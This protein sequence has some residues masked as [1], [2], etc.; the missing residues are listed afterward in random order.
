MVDVSLPVIW[1]LLI[2]EIQAISSL[3]TREY[4]EI[5]SSWFYHSNKR[6]YNCHDRVAKMQNMPNA[7]TR[8]ESFKNRNGC[9]NRISDKP[10]QSYNHLQFH[11]CYCNHLDNSFNSYIMLQDSYNKGFLPFSDGYLEQ[12]NKVMEIINLITNLN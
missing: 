6:Q 4:V 11:N 3:T 7:Q 10:R 1:A 9:D 8:I 12:P 2:S 5:V